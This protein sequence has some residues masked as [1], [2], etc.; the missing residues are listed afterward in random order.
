[1]FP[2]FHLPWHMVTIK[3]KSLNQFKSLYTTIILSHMSLE[4]ASF[5][6]TLW[7][8][9]QQFSEMKK[10]FLWQLVIVFSY[11]YLVWQCPPRKLFHKSWLIYFK[12]QQKQKYVSGYLSMYIKKGFFFVVKFNKHKSNVNMDFI[13]T[14][15]TEK[16]KNIY[17][18]ENIL[19]FFYRLGVLLILK[20]F[21]E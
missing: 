7:S 5:I 3:V 6:Y 1:M 14:M 19:T 8:V 10:I 17:R 13:V 11:L 21:F 16:K 20:F 12:Q 2:V 9:S 18:V 4:R 15:S